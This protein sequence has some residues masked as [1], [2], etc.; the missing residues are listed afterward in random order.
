MTEKWM[1][2]FKLVDFNR[3]GTINVKDRDECIQSFLSVYK[4]EGGNED[5]M[6][7]RLNAFWDKIVFL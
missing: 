4:P 5:T 6:R 2:S 7:N 3:D 1:I